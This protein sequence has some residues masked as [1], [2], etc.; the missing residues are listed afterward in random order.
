MSNTYTQKKNKARSG[1]IIS[2]LKKTRP[3]IARCC[4]LLGHTIISLENSPGCTFAILKPIFSA[5]RLLFAERLRV[6]KDLERDISKNKTFV[7]RTFPM[8]RKSD[9]KFAYTPRGSLNRQTTVRPLP[10]VPVKR[11]RDHDCHMFRFSAH[12]RKEN[13]SL[14]FYETSRSSND[15]TDLTTTACAQ[16][17]PREGIVVLGVPTTVVQPAIAGKTTERRWY[18]LDPC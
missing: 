13:C 7:N 10:T 5:S 4:H 18:T 16:A 3:R 17:Q 12:N 8:R 2:R 11:R 14:N 9:V 1:N 6:W 15:A